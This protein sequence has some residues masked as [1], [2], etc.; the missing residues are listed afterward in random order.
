MMNPS[1]EKETKDETAQPVSRQ[2]SQILKESV[3]KSIYDSLSS[4]KS[5]KVTLNQICRCLQML[6]QCPTSATLDKIYSDYTPEDMEG[7]GPDSMLIDL[8]VDYCGHSCVYSDHEFF[9]KNESGVVD[10][11]PMKT[12]LLTVGDCFTDKECNE[13]FKEAAPGTDGKWPYDDFVKKLV[14]AYPRPQ[15]KKAR[16]AGTGKK[17]SARK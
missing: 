3:I 8:K 15:S 13:F 16:S 9:D 12:M 5:R 7:I 4:A 17:K 6:N 14:D 10:T 11:E 2:D 1:D